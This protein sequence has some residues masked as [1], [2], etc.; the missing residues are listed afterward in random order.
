MTPKQRADRIIQ[1][2][3][4]LA[5]NQRVREE[6]KKQIEFEIQ[7]AVDQVYDSSVNLDEVATGL[8]RKKQWVMYEDLI[9]ALRIR[10]RVYAGESL[11]GERIKTGDGEFLKIR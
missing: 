6:L 11:I 9:E 8:L 4:W 10:Q 1:K 7:E 3:N 2:H 5:A